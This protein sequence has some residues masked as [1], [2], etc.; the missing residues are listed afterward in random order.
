M[1]PL[2]ALW[3][4]LRALL[5]GS[6]PQLTSPVNAGYSREVLVT[7]YQM[8]RGWVRTGLRAR[9]SAAE[10]ARG[11]SAPR[12]ARNRSTRVHGLVRGRKRRVREAGGAAVG[13]LCGANCILEYEQR[14]DGGGGV[15]VHPRPAEDIHPA[16]PQDTDA[17]L[18]T[19]VAGIELREPLDLG[20]DRANVAA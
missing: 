8:P 1:I 15:V 14:L 7:V 19:V 16:M 6:R 18:R 9:L 10:T 5:F 4:F 2:L 12:R 3:T 17:V 13:L 11:C 20:P